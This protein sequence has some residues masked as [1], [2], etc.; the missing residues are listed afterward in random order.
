M[1]KHEII[2]ESLQ[3]K[4]DAKTEYIIELEAKNKDMLEALKAWTEYAVNKDIPFELIAQTRLAIAKAEAAWDNRK[5]YALPIGLKM[6]GK[7]NDK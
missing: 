3:A 5:P 4:V 1:T 7:A 2:I 6:G